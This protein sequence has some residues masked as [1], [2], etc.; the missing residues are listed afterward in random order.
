M[1]VSRGRTHTRALAH[2]PSPRHS[3]ILLSSFYFTLSCASSFRFGSNSFIT[4]KIALFFVLFLVHFA[5]ALACFFEA[6]KRQPEPLSSLMTISS[7]L[8]NKSARTLIP[9]SLTTSPTA[10]VYPV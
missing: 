8:L 9:Y 6:S 3:L 1:G 7:S 5:P 2:L 4:A 10:C